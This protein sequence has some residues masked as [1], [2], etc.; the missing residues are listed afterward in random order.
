MVVRDLDKDQAICRWFAGE[1]LKEKTFYFEEIAAAAGDLVERL[2]KARARIIERELQ[3]QSEFTKEDARRLLFV[4]EKSK[5]E[6]APL[7]KHLVDLVGQLGP[8][9]INMYLDRDQVSDKSKPDV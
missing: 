9:V 5:R 7:P 4:V 8:P 1:T 2:E 3:R 6:G